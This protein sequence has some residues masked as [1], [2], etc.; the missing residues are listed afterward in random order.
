[1]EKVT[2]EFTTEYQHNVG[3]QFIPGT[4]LV[5]K[6]NV[7]DWFVRRE[8][9]KIVSKPK[10]KAKKNDDSVDSGSDGSPG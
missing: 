10:R 9:A 5:M 3:M 4:R 7:A 2:V 1:M 6:A 8:L